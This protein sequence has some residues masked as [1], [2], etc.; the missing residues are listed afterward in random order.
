TALSP[1]S[2]H[3]ALPISGQDSAAA[4][5]PVLRDDALNVRH[6]RPL[7]ARHRVAPHRL[8]AVRL[9]PPV[10]DA[11]AAGERH[12]AVDDE[13]LAVRAVRSEEHTAELQSREHV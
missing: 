10:G 12:A 4:L 6:D 9:R 1:P 13:E 11:G 2:L 5:E 3:A 7:D 8:A